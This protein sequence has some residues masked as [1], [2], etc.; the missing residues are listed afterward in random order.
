[1]SNQLF[2]NF[3]LGMIFGVGVVAL[4][5]WWDGEFDEKEEEKDPQLS[6][7]SQ[8]TEDWLDWAKSVDRIDL[9]S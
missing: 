7:L 2:A 1:M 6:D 9:A 4:I 3:L 5:F 8:R